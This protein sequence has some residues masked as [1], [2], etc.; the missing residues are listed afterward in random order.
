MPA[1]Q[2]FKP[3]PSLALPLRIPRT[4]VLAL[5]ASPMAAA[6]QDAVPL[7]DVSSGWRLARASLQADLAGTSVDD[8]AWP[9]VDLTAPWREHL[10]PGYDGALWYRRTIAATAVGGAEPLALLVGPSRHGSYRV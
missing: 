6:A 9:Q 3:N 2:T 8:S 5:L 1:R 10:A 7:S 4:L